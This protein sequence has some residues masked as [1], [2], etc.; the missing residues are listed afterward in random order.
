MSGWKKLQA[1]VEHQEGHE[2]FALMLKQINA[3]KGA[4]KHLLCLTAA[5]YIISNA[6]SLWIQTVSLPKEQANLSSTGEKEI[7]VPGTVHI[8]KGDIE[9]IQI[10]W[11]CNNPVSFT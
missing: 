2:R 11:T 4:L 3:R 8:V 1:G 7:K 5:V 9:R 6:K 10:M